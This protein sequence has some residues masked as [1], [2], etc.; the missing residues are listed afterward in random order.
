MTCLVV[1]GP[2]NASDRAD[3]EAMWQVLETNGLG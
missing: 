1:M 2:E 3:R